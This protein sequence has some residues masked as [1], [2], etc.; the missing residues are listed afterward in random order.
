MS[1][2]AKL[3]KGG[4]RTAA[5]VEGMSG[6]SVA[7]PVVTVG[8]QVEVV[9]V[10]AKR[11]AAR[12]AEVAEVEVVDT[13]IVPLVEKQEPLD[14]V[15]VDAVIGNDVAIETETETGNEQWR[16]YAVG[17]AVAG[18]AR[19]RLRYNIPVTVA[20]INK[21]NEL[22]AALISE[23]GRYPVNRSL[24]IAAAIKRVTDDPERYSHPVVEPLD[25][26]ISGRITADQKQALAVTRFTPSG[27]R[28]IS[29]L[30]AHAVEEILTS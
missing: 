25:A 21:L 8:E 19:A 2:R 26:G 27:R 20:S 14:P 18:Q 7:P 24:L 28:V 12:V 3:A 1:T 30:L 13:E 11:P 17:P 16:A 23:G 5:L 15:I 4:M 22:D 9:E 29:N 6:V 10:K